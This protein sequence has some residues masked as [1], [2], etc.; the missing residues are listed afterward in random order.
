MSSSLGSPGSISSRDSSGAPFIRRTVS[1]VIHLALRDR[2]PVSRRSGRLEY[3]LV[4]YRPPI[5]G[6]NVASPWSQRGVSRAEIT[7]RRLRLDMRIDVT[8][9]DR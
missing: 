6:I 4:P 5:A 2:T 7:I 1:V 3:R 9:M 8:Q